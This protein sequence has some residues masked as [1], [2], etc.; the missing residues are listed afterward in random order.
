ML[1]LAWYLIE[2]ALAFQ[3]AVGPPLGTGRFTIEIDLDYLRREM[4][5]REPDLDETEIRQRIGIA[6]ADIEPRTIDVLRK[7]LQGFGIR[8]PEISVI[9]DQR[10]RFR[11]SLPRVNEDQFALAEQS[12]QA[13]AFLEFRL[14]HAE[15]SRLTQELF[16]RWLAPE[17]FRIVRL[18]YRGIILPFYSLESGLPLDAE[19]RKR[20]ADFNAP[21]GFELLLERVTI[22]GQHVYR[23]YFVSRRIMLSGD[24]ISKA[25]VDYWENMQAVVTIEFNAEGRRRFARLTEDYAPGGPKNP[26]FDQFRELAMIIDGTLYSAP[27]IREAIHGGTAVISGGFDHAEAAFLANILRAGA[28]PAP[29]RI[30]DRQFV[31]P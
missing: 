20:I 8:N 9:P 5:L 12:L 30:V 6:I 1:K 18:E 22:R 11:I 13:V 7:R 27:V 3:L 15:N 29:L 26:R 10:H 17:G 23:P 16:D 4:I 14:V 19:I 25:K 2:L 31:L 24:T 21:R 28:L